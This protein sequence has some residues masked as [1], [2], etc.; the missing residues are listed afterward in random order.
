MNEFKKAAQ[1]VL[2]DPTSK[3][4][5]KEVAQKILN[6]IKKT[7]ERLSKELKKI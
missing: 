2:N 3:A 6:D 1:K 7:H 4:D 5:A